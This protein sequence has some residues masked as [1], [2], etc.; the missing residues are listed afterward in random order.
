MVRRVKSRWES[1]GAGTVA[2]MRS[3]A[4]SVS[5]ALLAVALLGAAGQAR[6]GVPAGQPAAAPATLW[7]VDLSSPAGADNVAWRGGGL[8]LRDRDRF[9]V[10]QPGGAGSG[11]YVSAAH[12]LA[13]PVSRVR[14]RTAAVVPAGAGVQ[15][16]VRGSRPDGSWAEW[17]PVPAGGVV[18]LG[19]VTRQ[20]QARLMLRSG[21]GGVPRVTALLLQAD[22]RPGARDT[23]V[24]GGRTFRLY[25]TREGLV[26]GT[27]ANGHVI[28]KHDHFAGL[29]SRRALSA[30][31]T[32]QYVVRVCN[33]RNGRCENAPVWDVGPWNT[34]DDYWHPRSRRQSWRDLHRGV[35]EAQ[36]AFLRGYHHGKDQY[37]R[38]VTN[39]AGIDLADGTFWDGLHMTD[40][41]Y[42]T[43]TFRWL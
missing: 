40:N 38:T 1:S 30:K 10:L 31:G 18:D 9:P 5:T 22:L 23:A 20:V 33:P 11:S 25:A 21:R 42:V 2:A 4:R 29:P 14:V 17:A 24:V 41:G 28:K 19:L 36:A 32:R 34:T 35:P 15:V 26:G 12:P 8:T 37:G 13:S 39:P 3:S 43:V 16:D 27:T 6:A 7:R